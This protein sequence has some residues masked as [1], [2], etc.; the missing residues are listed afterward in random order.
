MSFV[1]EI[2]QPQSMSEELENSDENLDDFSRSV[3]SLVSSSEAKV[4]VSEDIIRKVKGI[5]EEFFTEVLEVEGELLVIPSC[6]PENKSAIQIKCRDYLPVERAY[7]GWFKFLSNSKNTDSEIGREI[8]K[9]QHVTVLSQVSTRNSSFSF[10][11]V[12]FALFRNSSLLLSSGICIKQTYRRQSDNTDV[13]K[14]V[15]PRG[16]DYL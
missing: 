8:E 1:V 15:M 7:A 11:F 16:K 14:L 4:D 5:F 6:L 12:E 3:E 13:R 10:F 9:L 2:P